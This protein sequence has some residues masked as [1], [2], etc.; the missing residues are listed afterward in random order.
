MG[1]ANTHRGWFREWR[2]TRRA[3]GLGASAGIYSHE[4]RVE[5]P[6]RFRWRTPALSF[7]SS[8]GGQVGSSSAKL[9]EHFGFTSPPSACPRRL[10]LKMTSL[11]LKPTPFC[12][13]LYSINLDAWSQ[14]FMF[15]NPG[16]FSVICIL[17]SVVT[18]VMVTISLP[19]VTDSRQ[20]EVRAHRRFLN[21]EATITH[22]GTVLLLTD[23]FG[24]L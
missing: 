23:P 18:V 6:V 2:Q 5:I 12:L 13:L 3:R 1:A 10:T 17:I 19:P 8:F 9:S 16:M 24:L 15:S 7:Q 4:H 21:D 14:F 22:L 20:E 11:D